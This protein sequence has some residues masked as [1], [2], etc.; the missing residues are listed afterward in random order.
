MSNATHIQQAPLNT[1]HTAPPGAAPLTGRAVT[2]A[3]AHAQALNPTPR[4]APF[5]RHSL[6]WRSSAPD[7]MSGSVG[8]NAAQLTP[9]SC[10]SSTY[11]T[12]ASPPPKR[13]AFICAHRARACSQ[14]PC[15]AAAGGVRH[16]DEELAKASAHQLRGCAAPTYN[17]SGVACPARP[18]ALLC[19]SKRCSYAQGP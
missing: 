7:T 14:S 12:T 16:A 13:S 6:T 8:W 18:D 17:R 19:K 3:L 10:P 4:A 9:R 2:G 1:K 5:M 11:L 15:R